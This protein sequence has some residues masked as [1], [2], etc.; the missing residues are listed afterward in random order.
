MAQISACNSFPAQG[1]VKEGVQ[2]APPNP[3]PH[4]ANY[5]EYGVGSLVWIYPP[6]VCVQLRTVQRYYTGL[7]YTVSILSF[8]L[9][10]DQGPAAQY[11]SA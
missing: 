11:H 1:T 5:T 7:Y 9:A 6:F 8:D 10:T 3:L 4:Y 2:R